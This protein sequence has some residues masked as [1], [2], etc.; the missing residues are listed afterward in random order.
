MKLQK[1]SD[2]KEIKLVGDP[3]LMQSRD[4]PRVYQLYK[5]YHEKN[6]KMYFKFTQDE[7]A[8]LLMPKKGLVYTYVIE[9]N[10]KGITDFITYFAMDCSLV[11]NANHQGITVS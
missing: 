8:H 7:L 1:L 11:E 5:T 9:N 4:I 10:E 6:S 3:R 2:K